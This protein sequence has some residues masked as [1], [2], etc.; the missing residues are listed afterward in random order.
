MPLKNRAAVVGFDFAAPDQSVF[1]L[2]VGKVVCD[3]AEVA[4]AVQAQENA[5][6]VGLFERSCFDKARRRADIPN[7]SKAG[8]GPD[9][10]GEVAQEPTKVDQ[11]GGLFFRNLVDGDGFVR[12]DESAVEFVIVVDS[13]IDFTGFVLAGPFKPTTQA[14][15]VVAFWYEAMLQKAT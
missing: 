10:G 13:T 9:I 14:Y 8:K 1:F 7:V 6:C 2:A 5:V 4:D 11:I 3:G 12:K 15:S